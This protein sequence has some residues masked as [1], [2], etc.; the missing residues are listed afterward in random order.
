MAAR[1]T[2]A[3]VRGSNPFGVTSKHADL[4]VEHDE[5]ERIE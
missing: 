1:A 5:E 4:Q 2:T 3:E